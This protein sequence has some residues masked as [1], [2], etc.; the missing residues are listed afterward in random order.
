MN[1]EVVLCYQTS[2]MKTL[3]TLLAILY[4]TISLANPSKLSKSP[5][6]KVKDSTFTFTSSDGVKLHVR[7]AGQ[8]TPC[9][10]VHGGPGS[11]SWYFEAMPSAKIIESKM[12]MVYL[13][14]RGS[15]RSGSAAN[16]DY[17]IQ[18]MEKDMEELREFL[19][20]KN[21]AIM[22]HSFGGILVTNYAYHFPKSIS[23]MFLIHGTLDIN[24]SINSH[25]SFGLDELKIANREPYLDTTKPLLQRLSMVHDSLQK[26][27]T[28]YKLMYRNA[29]E[30]KINDSVTNSAGN[31][32]WEF[33]NQVWN[34]PEY[35]SDFSELTARIK[36][37]VLVMTGRTDYA[38]GPDHYRS[39]KF[40]KREIVYY[41]GGHAP[42]QEEPQWFAEK[43]ISFMG[44]FN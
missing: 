4:S 16:K 12:Q 23:A 31:L 32:N 29:E 10:F 1:I 38:I 44:N 33:A 11:T 21:W 25:I 7:V 14:Q 34:L 18:R 20:Y 6:L 15:G 30:K 42:F 40:P 3:I 19:G 37:P 2:T 9:L 24:Y 43:I 28:W 13:D 36:C 35:F 39:F 27:G 41:N 22:G 5:F 26:K 17:S 8:G